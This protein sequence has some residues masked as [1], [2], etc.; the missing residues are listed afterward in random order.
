MRLLVDDGED[1]IGVEDFVLFAVQFNFRA[2]VLADEHAVSLF[3][4]E[5]HLFAIVIGFT[6][7]E[8]DDDAFRGFF[9]GAIRDD[10]ATLLDFLLF[11]RFDQNAVTERSYVNCHNVLLVCLFD[12]VL[13]ESN[14]AAPATG[15]GWPREN[16]DASGARQSRG[17]IIRSS[18][19]PPLRRR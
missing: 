13:V 4:F 14:P 11:S 9:L 16:S 15:K 1:V 19:R 6:G 3:D 12:L 2:A 17:Q 8:S 18:S 7:A 5:G 10:N